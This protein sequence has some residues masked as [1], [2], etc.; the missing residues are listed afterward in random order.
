MD[1]QI[2]DRAVAGKARP[3]GYAYKLSRVEELEEVVCKSAKLNYQTT[4]QAGDPLAF[5]T[6]QFEQ[7]FDNV[8]SGITMLLKELEK[9]TARAAKAYAKAV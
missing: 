3:L 1:K 9:D 8:R 5:I 2:S 6:V 4:R 7:L